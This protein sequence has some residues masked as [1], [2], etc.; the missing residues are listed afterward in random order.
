[1]KR[2]MII[3]AAA[4]MILS[5]CSSVDNT[6]Q[7]TE[8]TTAPIE[9]TVNEE[10]TSVSEEVIAEDEPAEE[11]RVLGDVDF[12]TIPENSLNALL[13]E[14][15]IPDDSYQVILVVADD[16]V[17]KMYLMERYSNGLWQVAYGPFGAEIGRNGLGKT[18][19]GDGK[20]PIGV[21][22]L[23][24]AFGRYGAPSGTIWPWRDTV[25]GDLW[26]EDSNSKYYNLFVK[27]EEIEDKDWKNGS[28][29]NISAYD[30]A[31][32]VRYNEE[33]TPSW[34]V[35]YSFTAGQTTKHLHPAVQLSAK[36]T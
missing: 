25:A 29:L 11:A 7:D 15:D 18:K 2:I 12:D 28:N 6:N 34:E 10:E 31:I 20:S 27:E 23:G 1:M 5:G 16:D 14:Q 32:E 9:E 4:L 30:R 22:E 19:E 21:F 24:Y 3:I 33:R 13:N 8:A 36:I 17:E 26:I 35:Q